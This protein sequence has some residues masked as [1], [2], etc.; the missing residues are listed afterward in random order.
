[1]GFNVLIFIGWVLI[2]YKNPL[3]RMQ[4][5]FL[6]KLYQIKPFKTVESPESLKRH[7]QSMIE[8]PL[9]LQL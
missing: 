4:D 7:P 1:M 9:Q 5:Q 8:A 6:S 2:L 3:I